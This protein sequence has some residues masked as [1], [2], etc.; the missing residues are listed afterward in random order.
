[1]TRFWHLETFPENRIFSGVP[2][3]TIKTS[4]PNAYACGYFLRLRLNFTPADIDVT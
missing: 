4:E 3:K 2:P 1:M